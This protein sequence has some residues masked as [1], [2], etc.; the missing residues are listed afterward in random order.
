MA[1]FLT[2]NLNNILKKQAASNS[3]GTGNNGETKLDRELNGPRNLSRISDWKKE[4]EKRLTHNRSLPSHARVSEYDVESKFFEDYFYNG[5]PAW[6]KSCAKQLISLGEPLK[7]IMKVLGFSK[8]T[9]PILGFITDRYVI[10]N[11]IK[12]KLLNASTFKAIYNAVAKK[13]IANSELLVSNDYNIVYCRDLYKKPVAEILEYIKLQGKVL[14]PRGEEY[15]VEDVARNIKTFFYIEEV[16]E[17][18]AKERKA[19][20]ENLPDNVTLPNAKNSNTVLNELAFAKVMGGANTETDIENEDTETADETADETAET[21]KLSTVNAFVAQIQKAGDQRTAKARFFAALQ[22]LSMN[23]GNGYA[24][25]A[26]AHDVFSGITVPDVISASKAIA[27]IMKNNKLA[28]EDIKDFI[29]KI[30]TEAK[31][32]DL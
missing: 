17:Q 26:L 19:A 7:K 16:S 14:L 28:A 23:T 22:Y 3:S 20:I 9:N 31:R 13:L 1:D 12:T 4:L 29:S 24:S 10:N 21:N 18:D 15:S 2:V 11:L 5:N 25:K 30:L 27:N 32:I 8:K 6:D